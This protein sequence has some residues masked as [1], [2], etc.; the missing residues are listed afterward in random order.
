MKTG[1]A[2]VVAAV[3]LV[4][5]SAAEAVPI[6]Y[7]TTDFGTVTFFAGS[8]QETQLDFWGCPGDVTCQTSLNLTVGVPVVAR[9]H[10]FEYLVGINDG[11]LPGPD[12]TQVIETIFTVGS[13]SAVLTQEVRF[14]QIA[15]NQF[16][17][18]ISN[19]ETVTLD[20]G[21][22]GLLDITANS[23][24]GQPRSGARGGGVL[25]ATFLLREREP[26]AAVPEPAS[27]VLL[28][29]GLVGLGA[30]WRRRRGRR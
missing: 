24:A 2:A 29:G 20:L 7:T 22:L 27:A 4:A 16:L 21:P 1:I 19:S 9:S 15:N 6:N 30:L 10:G 26:V 28:G 17:L 18:Q 23:L 8:Q 25:R 5:G 13:Q 3:W 11:G 12:D 14:R